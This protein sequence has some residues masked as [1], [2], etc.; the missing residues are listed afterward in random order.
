MKTI[1]YPT[2]CSEHSI[3]ALQYAYNLST[4]LQADLIVL[5]VFDI[6]SF[7]GTSMIRSLQQIERN[8]FEEQHDILKA[9]CKKHLGTTSSETNVR[10]EVVKNLSITDGILAKTKELQVDMLIIG[11]KDKHSNR[12]VLTGDIAKELITKSI[13]PLLVVPNNFNT[14]Q[15][16]TIVYAT[17]FEESDIRAIDRL[18]EVAQPFESKISVLHISA[19]DNDDEKSKMAWFKEMVLQKVNYKN[20]E[21]KLV[22]SDNIYEK[23]NAYVHDIK[24]DLVVMLERED[25]GIFKKL[26]HRDLV[27]QIESHT[28]IPLLSFNKSNSYAIT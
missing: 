24:A 17:D 10:I 21:F 23:L 25:Q 26:F 22:I 1:L 2:D 19:K 6:P 9:Y 27:K 4:K 16:K 14:E 8:A 15:I 5:H 20:I 11:M 18:I 28:D 13:C 7:P 12:G 3:A